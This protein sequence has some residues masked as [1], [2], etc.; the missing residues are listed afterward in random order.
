MVADTR[1]STPTPPAIRRA[2][3]LS[4]AELDDLADLLVACVDGGASLGFLAPL[5]PAKARDWW[6]R[7]PR[8]GVTL[9][10]AERDGQ[11]VAS[12]QLHD[13]ES[14]N[15]AHRGE[16]AKLMV[17]P[18]ARRQGLARALMGALEN[19][20]RAAGKTLLVLDTRDGDPSNDLYRALGYQEAG[21]IPGYARDA[22]GSLS[23]TVYWYKPL[24][25]R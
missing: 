13:A 12:A 6:G 21:R 19:E 2:G 23:A 25:R 4:A 18:A 24:D 20:A 8:P 9:L 10:L 17:H 3:R 5:A 16:V 1:L 7:F 15:G 14:A 11:I 22:A